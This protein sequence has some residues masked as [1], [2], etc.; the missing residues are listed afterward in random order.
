M[1]TAGG[2]LPQRYIIFTVACC[3]FTGSLLAQS[4]ASNPSPFGSDVPQ[5]FPG[6]MMA[7]SIQALA[8]VGP[9]TV[10]AGSFGMGIFR[11]EDR[12][13]TWTAVNTGLSDPFIL[14]LTAGPNGM[15]YAG[16]FRGGVFRTKDGGKSWESFNG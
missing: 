14:S 10:Y 13:Q 15:I 11:S 6:P 3:L 4:N 5:N 2:Y 7:P 8:S 1:K 16:T 9:Q 12:G